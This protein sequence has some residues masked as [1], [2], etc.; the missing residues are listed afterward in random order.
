VKDG[1]RR[2]ARKGRRRGCQHEHG[3]V[4]KLQNR[5]EWGAGVE[6]GLPKKKAAM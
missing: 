5:G 2:S 6:K 4:V 1:L 3:S